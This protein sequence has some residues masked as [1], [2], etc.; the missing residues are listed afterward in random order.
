[1]KKLFYTDTVFNKN[2]Y[3]FLMK[4]DEKAIK[5]GTKTSQFK[6]RLTWFLIIGLKTKL[7]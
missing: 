3:I 4:Q 5:T 1:M 6:A 2:N 7:S